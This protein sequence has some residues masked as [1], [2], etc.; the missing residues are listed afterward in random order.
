MTPSLVA[1]CPRCGDTATLATR[2]DPA[3]LDPE[4]TD[5]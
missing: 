3:R 4:A 5:G 2:D 1:C